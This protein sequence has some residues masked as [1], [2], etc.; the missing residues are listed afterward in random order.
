MKTLHSNN[1]QDIVVIVCPSYFIITQGSDSIV[2]DEVQLLKLASIELVKDAQAD[3]IKRLKEA[4]EPFA[5]AYNVY[6]KHGRVK[7]GRSL[8]SNHPF[9]VTLEDITVAAALLA[10]LNQ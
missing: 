10:E 5:K 2:A 6:V 1:F 9:V 8:S 3:Q 4:L 7:H